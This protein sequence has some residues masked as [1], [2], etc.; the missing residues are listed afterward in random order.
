MSF[1]LRRH[2][3]YIPAHVRFCAVPGVCRQTRGSTAKESG[4]GSID[5]IGGFEL[6]PLSARRKSP[7]KL[8][9]GRI[10]A[11]SGTSATLSSKGRS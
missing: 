4:M 10:T 2:D 11:G 8:K 3:K 9:A 1:R 7:S 5:R 6:L